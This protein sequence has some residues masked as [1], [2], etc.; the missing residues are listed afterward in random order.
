MENN[1]LTMEGQLLEIISNE[2][3]RISQNNNL[4]V[5]Y[6]RICAY[7]QTLLDTYMGEDYDFP[8]DIDLLVKNLEPQIDVTYQPLNSTMEN[9]ETRMH[10]L[11]GRN[12]K[13]KNLFNGEIVSSILIDNESNRAEQRYALAHELAHYIMHYS[14]NILNSEYCVMPMLFR[15]MEEMV[16]DCF[17]TFLLIPTPLFV[18]EFSAYIGK[19]FVPVKT[20]EWLRY[21]S[22]VSEVAY[23]NVAIGYQMIR[24]V[25]GAVYGINTGT[26]KIEDDQFITKFLEKMKEV[27][28]PEVVEQL[29]Y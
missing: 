5:D 27:M 20:S 2:L 11:V 9:G 25:C 8:I 26:I 16:A 18:K 23:E 19:Q 28:I 14:E 12:L 22:I 6:L 3:K 15:E 13:R 17:A 29:F 1:T 10:R 4:A 21:L 7:A 24:Y